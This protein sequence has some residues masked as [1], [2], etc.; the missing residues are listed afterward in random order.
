MHPSHIF[1]GTHSLDANWAVIKAWLDKKNY[2]VE[3]Y[4]ELVTAGEDN[5]YPIIESL[6]GGS[7]SGSSTDGKEE[8][9]HTY[10]FTNADLDTDCNPDCNSSN[11]SNKDKK[12]RPK[13]VA[14]DAFFIFDDIGEDLKNST[15]TSFLTRN[16]HYKATV[17]IS[18]QYQNDLLPKTRKNTNNMIVF[19]HSDDKLQ[20]IHQN[21]CI[22]CPFE[23]FQAV[24]N[25]CVSTPYNFLTIDREMKESPK[26]ELFT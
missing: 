25:H 11:T 2:P 18:T 3:L 16:R 24:Y 22:T 1:C 6:G 19:G 23:T 14:S 8:S 7:S 17:V 26:N 12:K 21:A 10:I 5:L 9:K 15:L 20:L 4:D 13:Q